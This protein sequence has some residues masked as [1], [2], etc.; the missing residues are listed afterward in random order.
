MDTDDNGVADEEATAD[1]EAELVLA[2]NN[3]LVRSINQGA[4]FLDYLTKLPSGQK[5][6]NSSHTWNRV[7]KV[8]N[9]NGLWTRLRTD[10]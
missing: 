3:T 2:Q 5:A 1:A 7:I 6:L 8:L 4:G 9:K 10:P